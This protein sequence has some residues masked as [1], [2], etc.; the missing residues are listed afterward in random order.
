[1]DRKFSFQ[2]RPSVLAAVVS[3]LIALAVVSGTQPAAAQE[4]GTIRLI[5]GG[6]EVSAVADASTGSSEPSG[7]NHV[8][9]PVIWR[10]SGLSLGGSGGGIAIFWA[11]SRTAAEVTKGGVPV[12][13][14]GSYR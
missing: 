5:D 7:Q 9:I 11:A 13:T 1:M 4:T 14:A 2:R 12:I 10:A 6:G 3:V 8:S